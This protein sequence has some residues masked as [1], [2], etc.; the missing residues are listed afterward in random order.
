MTIDAALLSNIDKPF[1]A[2]FEK[3]PEPEHFSVG[4]D[5]AEAAEVSIYAHGNTIV[6]ENA[7]ADIMVFDAMGR[8]IERVA[9]EPDRTEIQVEGTGVYVVKTGN[10]SKRVMIK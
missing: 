3:N 6:V 9:A 4:V 7:D 10:A 1:T 5:D 8:M 2:I